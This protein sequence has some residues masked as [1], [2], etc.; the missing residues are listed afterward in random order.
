MNE[1]PVFVPLATE[2]FEDF[3]SRGKRWEVRRAERQWNRGQLRTGRKT[4]LSCG[5]SG[6]RL[7]GKIGRVVFGS[8]QTIFRLIPFEQIEPCA[9]N[10]QEA[11]K[12]N[13]ELLGPVKE[14]VAFEVIL[15]N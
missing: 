15:E 14:Y 6:P 13:L 9:K 5:Y 11:I 1:T 8:L 10:K 3:R 2:S 4:T 7:Y 12:E